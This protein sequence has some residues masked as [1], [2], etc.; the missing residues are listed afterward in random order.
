[1][2]G[3]GF[4]V[5]AVCGSIGILRV[6]DPQRPRPVQVQEIK[7]SGVMDIPTPPQRPLVSHS[8]TQWNDFL[9]DIKSKSKSSANDDVTAAPVDLADADTPAGASYTATSD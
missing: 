5:L 2:A 9:S 6:T 1:M 3:V 8:T 4:G 7:L